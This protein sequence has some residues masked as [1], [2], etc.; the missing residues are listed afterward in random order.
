MLWTRLAG[1][2]LADIVAPRFAL[3]G[4]VIDGIAG[5]AI[6]CSSGGATSAVAVA[7]T[8]EDTQC[9]DGNALV[10]G[11]A[12]LRTVEVAGGGG[13]W[14]AAITNGAS[15]KAAS[16]QSIRWALGPR[17]GPWSGIGEALATTL[18]D[19]VGGRTGAE[20]CVITP[21]AAAAIGTTATVVARS[22]CVT[23][24]DCE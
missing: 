11:G 22:A 24:R 16:S 15:K 19:T 6:S 2:E 1:T 3:G 12:A 20:A 23:E 5:G 7:W 21:V 4:G 17:V 9:G 8:P 13:S 14:G 18:L 10:V